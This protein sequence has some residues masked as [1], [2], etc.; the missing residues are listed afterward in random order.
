MLAGVGSLAGLVALRA[1]CADVLGFE[2]TYHLAP[3]VG[4]AGGGTGGGGAGGDGLCS[5]KRWPPPPTQS[6]GGP[7]DVD[8]VVAMRTIDFGE[9]DVGDGPRVGFDLDARCTCLGEEGSCIPPSGSGVDLCDGP[10]GIDNGVAAAFNV[11]VQ[12]YPGFSTEAQNQGIADGKWSILVRVSGY[13]GGLH[14]AR[15]NVA[16]FPSSGLSK[17]PCLD[18]L[19]PAWDGADPWP[20]PHTSLET[21]GSGGAGG[22]RGGGGGD[23]A[24]GGGDGG[25]SAT[26]G[27][28]GQGGAGG[29][30]CDGLPGYD[31]DAA[32]FADDNA[33]V[34]DG[35]LVASLPPTGITFTGGGDTTTFVLT[36]GFLTARINQVGGAWFLR[37]GLLA[38]R[39]PITEVF[40]FISSLEAN[41]Q[42]LCTDTTAYPPIKGLLCAYPDVTANIASP[43]AP[44]DAVSFGMRFDAEPAVLGT[45]YEAVE[46]ES[47]CPR[48]TNPAFDA[49]D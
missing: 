48:E 30:S 27:G 35:V 38:G 2:E 26:G 15:V 36:A 39:W 13:N 5:H 20:I 42:P 40:R 29:T 47:A 4:G 19:V 44:C 1:G 6:D 16:V 3:G 28:P 21:A 43:T 45:V 17:N 32:R 37:D 18:G 33:Y 49:C 23:G 14:D 7:D 34:T 41:D 25:A 22:G 31:T 9:G 24:S 10:G 12:F 11:V 46:N 8:F